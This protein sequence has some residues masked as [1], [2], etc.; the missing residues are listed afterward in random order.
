MEQPTSHFAELLKSMKPNWASLITTLI[1]SLGSLILA[2]VIAF[3]N[4]QKTDGS[5]DVKAQDLERRVVMLES[6]RATRAEVQGV[7]TTLND[8]KTDTRTRLSDMKGDLGQIQHLL[9][10]DRRFHQAEAAAK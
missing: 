10:E 5:N 7:A 3:G 8:F 1:T 6:D 9:M 4:H 2:G